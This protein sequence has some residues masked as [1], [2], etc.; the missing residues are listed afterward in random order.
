[1]VV[2]RK[3]KVCSLFYLCYTISHITKW[4]YN[5]EVFYK[6]LLIEF[7]IY[8]HV[9]AKMFGSNTVFEELTI[10]DNCRKCGISYDVCFYVKVNV[11]IL[12]D[13][14]TF[15]RLYTGNDKKKILHKFKKLL[16]TV[17]YILVQY[18]HA[19]DS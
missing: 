15:Y 3:K 10:F 16:S 6:M 9:C 12:H 7:I 4:L 2:Y 1:M 8:L 5:A 11:F 19:K 17:H 13:V 14:Y 18:M